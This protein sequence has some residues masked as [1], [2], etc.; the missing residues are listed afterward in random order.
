MVIA[1]GEIWWADLGSPVGSAPGFRRPVLVVQDDA[2]NRSRIQ[3]VVHPTLT[4]E[5]GPLG[6]TPGPLSGLNLD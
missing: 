6:C 1:Q 2:L 3:L 4:S 5:G